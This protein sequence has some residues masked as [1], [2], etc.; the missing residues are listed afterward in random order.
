[1]KIYKLVMSIVMILILTACNQSLGSNENSDPVVTGREYLELDLGSIEPNW[2]QYIEAT[3][4]EDGAIRITTDMVESLVDFNLEGIYNVNYYVYDSAGKT[5]EYTM[6]VKIVD[7]RTYDFS[8]IGEDTIYLDVD[9]D[10]VEQGI[11]S[12]DS[13]GNE[14]SYETQT[15]LDTSIIGE[16]T[17]DYIYREENIIITRTVIVEDNI[18]PT[19]IFEGGAEVYLEINSV[20]I[21]PSLSIDDNYFE[22]TF[23]IFKDGIVDAGTIGTYTIDYH[24]DDQSGNSSE[25]KIYNIHVVDYSLV[26]FSATQTTVDYANNS[27]YVDTG[28]EYT[29]EFGTTKKTF[30]D[31]TIN[32]TLIE[33]QVL[34]YVY[35]DSKGVQHE[36][37]INVNVIDTIVI[38]HGAVYEVD[39]FHENY[40]GT[41]QLERQIKQ[42]EIEEKYNVLIIYKNYASS[43]YWG[44]NRVLAINH[45]NLAGEPL[46]DIYWVNNLW[47]QELVRANAIADVSK[48]MSTLGHNIADGYNDIGSFQNGIYGFDSI[49]PDMQGGL[50]YNADLIESLGIDN[51]TDLYLDGNWNWSEFEA[52]AKSAQTAIGSQVDHYALGGMLS[53]YAQYMIPLNGGRLI[54][55]TIGRVSFNNAQAIETY[56][57]LSDL[58][59]AGLFEPNSHYDGGS[60]LWASGKVVMHPGDLWFLNSDARWASLSFDIGFVPYPVAD[61]YTDEYISPV[62]SAALYSIANGMTPQKEE[63]VFKIWNELQLWQTEEEENTNYLY[64]LHSKFDNISSIEAYL[65][66]HDKVYLDLTNLIGVSPYSENGWTRNINTAIED[67]T[68]RHVMD[69]IEPTYSQAL[70]YYLDE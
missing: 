31:D 35:T 9:S 10:Y 41:Y 56:D 57:F 1:M 21:E 60:N 65:E 52:W 27:A 19:F 11:V 50:Y 66:V 29:D 2:Q 48:Y 69:A 42:R 47:I 12:L 4:E 59:V 38:M 51:P 58:H 53:Y 54:D 26:K 39:P 7:N 43:A 61:D 30:S 14:F 24:V 40:S 15:E 68:Y 49:T 17:I 67:R 18:S 55:K 32:M 28:V 34:H 62:S 8:L 25:S 70:L 46:G 37:S 3:D 36:T 63:M 44:S 45:A 6:Q 23:L 20:Y 16:Q 64:S 5:V 13:N 22:D 33:I